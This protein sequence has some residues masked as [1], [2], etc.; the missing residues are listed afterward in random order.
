MKIL[1]VIQ[2]FYPAIGGAE[3]LMKQYL[4]YLS[5]NHDVTV[6][7]SNAEYLSDFWNATTKNNI[8]DTN[9]NYKI[10][11]FKILIPSDISPNEF[12][13]PFAISSFGPFCPKMWESLLN[14]D[15]KFDLIIASSF[16][17]DHIIPAFLASQKFN[18]PFIILPHIHLQFPH[19]H[20]TAT[21]LAILE[22]SNLIIVNT[23]EEKNHLLKNKILDEK[24]FVNPPSILTTFDESKL[25]DIRKKLKIDPQ[26]KIILFAGTKFVDKGAMCLV[27]AIEQL[28][29][30][31]SLLDLILIGPKSKEFSNFLKQKSEITRQHVH[32]LGIVD[33][34]EKT[35]IFHSCDIFAMPSRSESFGLVYLEAWL[36]KKPVIGC[37][38]DAVKNLI[39][40]NKNGLLVKFGDINELSLAVNTLLDS[41]MAKK[42]GFEGYKKLLEQ[43]DS[44][45]LCKVFENICMSIIKY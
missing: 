12:T 35:S 16:P 1:C 7:T 13:F 17:Y 27:D 21:K 22:N 15:E 44:K 45:K 5:L 38:I 39:D 37:N 18:I 29:A 24:I 41:D 34:D 2:R 8:I 32:D 4:D 43:Y 11:R 40:H 19:L 20:F 31:N 6:Y 3:N 30:K 28:R 10:H 14:M 42:L 36:H 23:K 26:S 25:F 9:K 33:D